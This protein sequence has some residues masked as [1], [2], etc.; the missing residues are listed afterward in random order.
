[1]TQATR[2]DLLDPA[3]VARLG[4]IEIVAAGVVFVD[5]AL[6]VAVL[7]LWSRLRTVRATVLEEAPNLR[8]A[9]RI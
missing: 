9:G 6:L 5:L 4:G 2:L 1:M 8:Q 7:V 3:E